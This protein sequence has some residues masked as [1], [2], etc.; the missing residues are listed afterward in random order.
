MLGWDFAHVQDDVNPNILR[1]FEDTL[2]LDATHFPFL[3]IW[4]R[5]Y[6]NF[7]LCR[8]KSKAKNFNPTHVYCTLTAQIKRTTVKC[9]ISEKTNVN[10]NTLNKRIFR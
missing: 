4:I 1:K 10:K 5:F 8:K 9:I 7:L 6:R 3:M 2:S